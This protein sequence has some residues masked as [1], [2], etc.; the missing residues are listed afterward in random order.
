M[1]LPDEANT[2][3]WMAQGLCLEVDPELFYPTP[4]DPWGATKHAKGVCAQCPVALQCLTYAMA[5]EGSL[6][7]KVRFGIWG[8]LTPTDRER[9]ARG[10]YTPKDAA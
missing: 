4:G 8:G 5:F 6:D 1:S 3:P 2:Q 7:R 10:T 9:L